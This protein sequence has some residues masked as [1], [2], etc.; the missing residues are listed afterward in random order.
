MSCWRT[1]PLGWLVADEFRLR[2]YHGRAADALLV[3]ELKS[4]ILILL[5]C[6]NDGED[7]VGVSC[8]NCEYS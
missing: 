6:V 3:A 4:E 7:I 2:A 8:D 1:E 5:C